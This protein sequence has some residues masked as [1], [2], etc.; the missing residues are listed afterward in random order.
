MSSGASEEQ[1]ELP[2][3]LHVEHLVAAH[4]LAEEV[5]AEAGTEVAELQRQEGEPSD[6][7]GTLP[8]YAD[9]GQGGEGGVGSV[10]RRRNQMM[11]RAAPQ[12][13]DLLS[14]MMRVDPAQRISSR[15]ICEHAWLTTDLD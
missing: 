3:E 9:D 5:A 2:G 1:V 7:F 8:L 15:G 11:R 6:F 14:R 12:L 13:F 10:G 4:E